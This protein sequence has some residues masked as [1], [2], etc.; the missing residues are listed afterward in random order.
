MLRT[1]A[2]IG[3]KGGLKV[4]HA[5]M[6][7]KFKPERL[8]EAVEIW[9]SGVADRIGAQPGFVRVQFYHEPT[10]EA[11]A[12]G[13]WHCREDAENFMKTGVFADILKSFGD[14]MAEQPRGGDYSLAYFDEA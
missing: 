4:Y 10:G 8:E 9:K 5:I 2:A 13:S 12:I 3:F 11:I 7:Y 14:C 1:L 6:H